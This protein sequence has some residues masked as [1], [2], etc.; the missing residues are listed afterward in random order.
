MCFVWIWEQRAIISPYSINIFNMIILYKES[1]IVY[2]V[3]QEPNFVQN[4]D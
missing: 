1:Y 4:L 2:Y 3:R